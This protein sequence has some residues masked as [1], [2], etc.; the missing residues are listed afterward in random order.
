MLGALPLP[1]SARGSAAEAPSGA[2][3]PGG[4]AVEEEAALPRLLRAASMEAS[5]FELKCFAISLPAKK[6]LFLRSFSWSRTFGSFVP[7]VL[8]RPSKVHAPHFTDI[9]RARAIVSSMRPDQRNNKDT[10]PST[11]WG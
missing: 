4:G 6:C 10:E 7:A 8:E 1:L 2:D 9:A 5:K 11:R 3:D